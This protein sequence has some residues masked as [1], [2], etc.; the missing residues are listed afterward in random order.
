MWGQGD[1]L[2]PIPSGAWKKTKTAPLP[3]HSPLYPLSTLEE[4]GPLLATVAM[5]RE[6]QGCI[7]VIWNALEAFRDVAGVIGVQDTILEAPVLTTLRGM[8]GEEG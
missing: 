6:G 8:K 7:Y 4:V 1:H 5:S 2:R 3:A